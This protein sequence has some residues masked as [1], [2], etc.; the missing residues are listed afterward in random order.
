MEHRRVAGDVEEHAAVLL[1]RLR[2]AGRRYVDEVLRAELEGAG[3]Y[4]REPERPSAEVTR[5]WS[6]FTIMGLGRAC[7]HA[8]SVDLLLTDEHEDYEG[9][10]VVGRTLFELAADLTYLHNDVGARLPKYFAHR[11]YPVS[12]AAE[13]ELRAKIETGQFQFPPTK[14]WKPIKNIC[15]ELERED[16]G[17]A[18]R[19]IYETFYRGASEGAHAAI[20]PTWDEFWK[21]HAHA[22]SAE[23]CHLLLVALNAFHRVA[24]IVVPPSSARSLG[25]LLRDEIAPLAWE[26]AAAIE[27]PRSWLKADY[28]DKQATVPHGEIRRGLWAPVLDADD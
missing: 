10:L 14:R 12:P 5:L 24:H 9:A 11:G 4:R 22:Y 7:R 20:Y 23:K 28:I 27:P 6:S 21:S 2:N 16:P 1:E 18:W 8:R 17:E 26:I 19:G 15:A 13:D 25:A 3:N